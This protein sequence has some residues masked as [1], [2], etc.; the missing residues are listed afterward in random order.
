MTTNEIALP[1]GAAARAVV[2]VDAVE[3]V[4]VSVSVLLLFQCHLPT[5][6]AVTSR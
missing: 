2:A 5:V 6:A 4:S 1:P 3:A